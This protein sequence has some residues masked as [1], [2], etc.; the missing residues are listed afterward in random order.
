MLF[1]HLARTSAKPVARHI[2]QDSRGFLW[3]L[4]PDG[5]NRYDGKSNRIFR[6]DANEPTSISNTTLRGVVEDESGDLW[7][8][9]DEGLNRYQIEDETFERL[10]KEPEEETSP[11]SDRIWSLSAGRRGKIWIGYKQGGF[12]LFD[13]RSRLFKHYTKH[14][15]PA[16][17][18][19]AV[20]NILE[21]ADGQVWIAT[22][23]NGLLRLSL[24]DEQ[25]EKVGGVGDFE[26]PLLS[27]QVSDILRD[28]RGYFWIATQE[29]GALRI[30]PSGTERTLVSDAI[31]LHREQT[32]PI[33]G[34]QDI[35][36]DRQGDMFFATNQGVGVFEPNSGKLLMFHLDKKE[37]EKVRAYSVHQDRTGRYWV[38]SYKGLYS[39]F[40]SNFARVDHFDGLID[41]NVL[42][43]VVSDSGTRWI[44]TSGGLYRQDP[45][46]SV[47][48]LSTSAQHDVPQVPIMSLLIDGTDLL[49][50]TFDRG[51]LILDRQ[52]QTIGSITN[53]KNQS[54]SISSNQ[55]TSMLRDSFGNLW[56]GTYGQGLSVRRR[57]ETEFLNYGPD[58]GDQTSLS[59]VAPRT[60]FIRKEMVISGLAL[61]L[62]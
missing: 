28:S 21:E 56:I 2:Y 10:L 9:T 47:L 1:L 34:V 18:D 51:V 27:E 13:P 12:S 58:T 44:G 55:I 24:T 57:G 49:V 3:I 48:N 26:I 53:E 45:G 59:Q 62:G 29:G 32:T 33:G 43:V 20:T 38:S 25:L 61:K 15:W 35:Y 5:L 31:D 30:D 40:R 60:R 46:G 54:G 4:T 37:E 50:G 16:L 42:S 23:G 41:E 6:S 52:G 36:E 39:G 14:A 11:H 19:D 8:A 22:E 7:F 17:T